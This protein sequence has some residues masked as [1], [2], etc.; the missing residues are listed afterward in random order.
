VIDEN[1]RISL[2]LKD[3]LSKCRELEKE[4]DLLLA[5]LMNHEPGMH[6][7]D[8]SS[9]DEAENEVKE[10]SGPKRSNSADELVEESIASTPAAAP[11]KRKRAP[12]KETPAKIKKTIEYPTD[13][14]G[15]PILPLQ[16][17]SITLISLGEI[18]LKQGFH[19]E[20][21]IYPIGFVSTKVYSST[22]DPN[23]T[24]TYTCSILDGGDAPKFQIIPQD[25]PENIVVASSTT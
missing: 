7:S 10:Q 23:G 17:N 24:T 13:E 3:S 20:K 1:D 8:T 12:K 25:D 22:K 15:Q 21:Y 18:S 16:L 4:R 19:S 11:G 5:R 6:S 14:D 9:A 2:L